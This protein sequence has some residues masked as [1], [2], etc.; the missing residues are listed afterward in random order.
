M[1]NEITKKIGSIKF[2][3]VSPDEIRKMSKIE[4]FRT[5]VA[6]EI[7]ITSVTIVKFFDRVE[8]RILTLQT[9]QIALKNNFKFITSQRRNRRKIKFVEMKRKN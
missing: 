4:I 6:K 8:K 2:S 9:E 5:N 3:C 1:T 7:D